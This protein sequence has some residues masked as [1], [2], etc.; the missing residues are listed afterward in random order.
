MNQNQK[1]AA[2]YTLGCKVNQY[3]TEAMTEIL[4]DAGYQIVDF[5]ETSDVYIINTCTVTARSDSKS[6][7]LIRKAKDKN[8]HSIVAVVG[9]YAQVA[10]D[11]IIDMPEVDL[12]VGTNKRHEIVKLIEKCSKNKKVKAVDDI[13]SQR[14][15]EKLLVTGHKGKTRAYVKIQDGCDQFCSYCIIPYARGPVRSRDM[16]ETI[17]EIK[18]LAEAGFKE[19]VFTGIQIASYGKDNGA[20]LEKLLVKTH[21]INGIHRIRLSSMELSL[22]TDSFIKTAAAMPKFCRHF[23]VSLQSGCNETLA[24]M[25]RK[26]TVEEYKKVIDKVRENIPD[27]AITTDI[28]VGFP[29]ETEEEFCQSY[30]FA[31]KMAFSRMHVFKYSRRKGTPADLYPNQINNKIKENRSHMML[32][33]AEDMKKDFFR[34][35]IGRDMNV[36]FEQVSDEMPGYAEGL[37]DNYIRVFVKGD[38]NILNTIKSCRLELRSEQDDFMIGYVE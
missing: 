12:V 2:L 37:T 17:Y 32:K 38:K 9:C 8:P 31:S 5:N 28:M 27:A 23:H 21:E 13:W 4:Q 24:R 19:V 10:Y 16:D 33:L 25:H 22:L 30:A 35:Y 20:D 18:K 7:T 11:K 36:L 3:E 14:K 26:Y 6:R 15:F 1:T 34:K 29:G